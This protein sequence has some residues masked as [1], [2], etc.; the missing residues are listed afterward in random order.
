MS[1]IISNQNVFLAILLERLSFC[2]KF[3]NTLNY[4]LTHLHIEDNFFNMK[5][6]TAKISINGVFGK[7]GHLD[8]FLGIAPANILFSESKAEILNEETGIG[9]QRPHNRAH[10]LDFMRYIKQDGASTIPL[11]FNLR[12]S[13]KNSWNIRTIE[14][15]SVCLEFVKGS[16]SL[17]LVDG[18]HRIGEL[19]KIEIPLAF[20]AFVGLDIKKEMSLFSV[21]NSKAKGLSTSLTDYLQSQ[22]LDDVINEAPHIFIAKR[23]NEDPG[24][25]WYKMIRYGG[26]TT[27]GLK[28]RTSLR[29]MQKSVDRYLKR[30]KKGNSL[31][32]EEQYF[33]ILS[34]WNAVRNV[35]RY[36]WDNHRKHLLTKGLGLYSLMLLLGDLVIERNLNVLDETS[37]MQCILPLKDRIDWSSKG[38]FSDAGGQKGASQVYEKLKKALQ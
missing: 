7:C 21:I 14:G 20:M 29:M 2:K 17:V 27:S 11:V 1:Q 37:F 24:S 22:L 33:V 23:L 38:M 15:N 36:A 13:Q 6:N 8:V 10:S 16:R 30:V 12:K 28:R 5:R 34:F 25:P 35:F 26:E 19:S 32:I 9:Y 3:Y 31:D 4:F 18:Q